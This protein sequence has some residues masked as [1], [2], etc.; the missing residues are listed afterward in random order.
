MINSLQ[1]LI[2]NSNNVNEINV[3][4]DIM[5]LPELR[6]SRTLIEGN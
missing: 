3:E 1:I 6:N 2:Y 4:T 5:E